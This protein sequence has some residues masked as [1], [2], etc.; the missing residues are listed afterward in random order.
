MYSKKQKRVGRKFRLSKMN[1]TNEKIDFSQT[2]NC[3]ANLADAKGAGMLCYAIGP[4]KKICFL[5][6]LETT[7]GRRKRGWCDLGGSCQENESLEDT[8]AREMEEES[9]GCIR[10]AFTAENLKQ[11]EFSCAIISPACSS[12]MSFGY[13]CFVKR[14]EYDETLPKRFSELR[15]TLIKIS[16]KSRIPQ[17]MHHQIPQ[18]FPFWRPGMKTESGKTVIDVTNAQI[19]DGFFEITY[20]ASDSPGNGT[21][22]EKLHNE[23]KRLIDTLD[24]KTAD[25]YIHWFELWHE[26]KTMLKELPK[27]T[28]LHPALCH[29]SGKVPLM[30]IVDNNF[31]EKESLAWWEMG[32]MLRLPELMRPC[33][34]PVTL[35]AA[36]FVSNACVND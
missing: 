24:K 10:N 13:V 1:A 17:R 7:G 4:N 8:A 9:M 22:E 33:F 25:R 29:P 11:G 28:R 21:T 32:E 23:R 34:V 15:Q 35:A 18:T 12:K 5:L 6:G 16:E 3:I 19:S 26:V 20:I 31:L 30:V 14:I 27:E 36:H 2:R